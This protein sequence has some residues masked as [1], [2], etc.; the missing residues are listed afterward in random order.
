[1]QYYEPMKNETLTVE[2][3]EHSTITY[4][5]ASG[6]RHNPNGPAVVCA[7]GDK[8]YYINGELHNENGPAIV[9]ADGSKAY[10]IKGE[11]LTKAE[12][13]A[14]QAKQTAPLHN[15]TTVIDGVE[16]TLMAK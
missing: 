14:W 2:T 12:F 10:Y 13:K 6:Q 9:W 16:Y 8:F 3:S 7:D 1:M 15:T 11:L 4:R 5:N